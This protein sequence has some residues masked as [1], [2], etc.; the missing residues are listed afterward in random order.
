MA[1]F[2]LLQHVGIANQ[3]QNVLTVRASSVH[4]MSLKKSVLF[5]FFFL[6]PDLSF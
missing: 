4:G 1:K 2:P 6:D 5:A 3:T